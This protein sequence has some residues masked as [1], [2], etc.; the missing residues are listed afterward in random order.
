MALAYLVMFLVMGVLAALQQNQQ[1]PQPRERDYFYT[2]SFL[3]WCLWIGLGSFSL[4][5]Q[6]SKIKYSSIISSLVFIISLILVPVN[7]AFVGWKIH[8]IAGNY[9]PFDYSYNILQSVEKDAIVFTNGD[10]DTFPVW[11]LQDV[12]GV[13][14]DVR[15]VNLSLGNTL[16]YVDQLKNREPWGAKK[17]PLSFSD[18]SIQK[19]DENQEGALSYDF[20]EEI[21]GIKSKNNSPIDIPSIYFEYFEDF[22]VVDNKNIIKLTFLMPSL[23]Y[24]S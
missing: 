21:M 22:I 18:E 1:D 7:M 2:G 3:V 4:I 23:I 8:S 10:N 6:L 13:R 15:I 20:G 9:L 16:W 14:R 17:I 12:A 19:D 5:E 11:W 24:L